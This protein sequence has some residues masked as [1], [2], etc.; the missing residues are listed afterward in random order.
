MAITQ[1]SIVFSNTNKIGKG[2]GIPLLKN[3]QESDMN[4]DI[5]DNISSEEFADIYGSIQSLNI[6]WNGA[7]IGEN[8]T[9]NTTGEVLSRY[10]VAI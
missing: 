9:L 3:G 2:T 1:N 4:A 5:A 7:E 10:K 6:N 8:K